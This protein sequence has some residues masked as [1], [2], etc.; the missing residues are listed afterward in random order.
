MLASRNR[1]ILIVGVLAALFAL[2]GGCLAYL[3]TSSGGSAAGSNAAGAE[4]ASTL[5]SSDEPSPG[6]DTG[7]PGAGSSDGGD[8][9]GAPPKPRRNPPTTGID[10]DGNGDTT[11]FA[12]LPFTDRLDVPLRVAA[13]HVAS[14]RGVI[15]GD[16]GGC[17]TCVGARLGPG[18][19]PEC[20]V[21][22][23]LSGNE[24]Y[25]AEATVTITL[26]M[27]AT[28]TDASLKPCGVAAGRSPSTSNPVGIEVTGKLVR[29]I[30][31]PGGQGPDSPPVESPSTPDP[32]AEPNSPDTQTV[33]EPESSS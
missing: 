17:S 19:D 10:L 15:V 27:N 7:A 23:R 18:A 9:E 16:P 3:A 31:V 5:A 25:P 33:P 29:T 11:C 28:C 24:P 8:D 2:G 32:D 30:E 22:V 1:R 20:R 12:V 26:T 14:T 4:P 13:V 21:G 6:S